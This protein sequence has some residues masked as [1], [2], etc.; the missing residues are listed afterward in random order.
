MWVKIFFFWSFIVINI[1]KLLICSFISQLL[2]TLTHLFI[3]GL[4][5]QVLNISEYIRS[6]NSNQNRKTMWFHFHCACHTICR[7]AQTCAHTL[8]PLS[9]SLWCSKWLYSVLITGPQ[10]GPSTGKKRPK[11]GVLCVGLPQ[12]QIKKRNT[13]KCTHAN[14]HPHF[15]THNVKKKWKAY[16][17]LYWYT[18]PIILTPLSSVVI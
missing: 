3:I 11:H 8:L 18:E 16:S 14:T 5:W 6:K 12:G 10:S 9:R 13:H 1:S 2:P 4:E 15:C 17:P 7:D